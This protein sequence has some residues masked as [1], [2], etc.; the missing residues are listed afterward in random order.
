MTYIWL[1]MKRCVIIGSGLGGLSCGCILAKNGYDVTVLEQGAQIGGCLQCFRRGSA[2]FETGMHFIGSADRG[3][4]LDTM[5]RYLGIRDKIETDRLDTAGY[6]VISF[7]GKSYKIANGR[8]N[9]ISS[10]SEHFPDSSRELSR[11]FDLV[12]LVASSAAMH[13]LNG[14]ADI[15]IS[16]EYQLR[17]V[18]DVLEETVSDA[19]LREVLAGIQMLYAGERNRTPFYIHAL[20]ADFYNKSAF[21][22]VGGS[23]NVADALA[24]KIIET[25]GRV[26]AMRKAVKIECDEAKATGVVTDN[27]EYFPAD[28]VISAIHPQTTMRLVDNGAL[29]R[30]CRRRISSLRNTTSAFTVY[31]KFRKDTVPYMRYNLYSYRGRTTW[32]CEK[33]SEESWPE[34]VLYMHFCHKSNPEYAE[35]GEAIAYMRFDEVERWLGTAVGQRGGEYEAFK[36]RKTEAVVMA[37]E[38]EFP[39]LSKNIEACYTSTPL[40]YLDYTGTP[41]GAMYGAARDVHAIGGG[42]V[43]PKTNIPNLLLAGQSVACHG[44]LGTLSGSFMACGEVLTKEEM[45]SQL[46]NAE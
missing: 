28:I 46:K 44:M 15:S 33:Y 43:T 10:L 19:R 30:F 39:G 1:K 25:G 5:L 13:S 35:T 24:C 40:T 38:D 11:Y 8:E 32:N 27:G 7:G 45:L 6:D 26:L 4:T 22:I 14:N 3:Q 34:S 41:Q 42:H 18:N 37:L 31:L 9:F 29:S 21:R 36:R 16:T 23:C 12:S 17:S 20:I 2:V